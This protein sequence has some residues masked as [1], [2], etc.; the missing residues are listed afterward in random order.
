MKVTEFGLFDTSIG[1]CSI[2]WGEHGLK[3]VRLP[4]ADEARAL[5]PMRRRLPRAPEV[6]SPPL[7]RAAADRVDALLGG[8]R[9]VLSDV[10]PD[11]A[12]V[13]PFE[14]RVYECVCAIVRGAALTYGEVAARMGERGAARAVGEALGR[15]TFA[16]IMPCHRV[17]AAGGR[18]CGFSARDGVATKL[19]MLQGRGGPDRG[20]A[21][22]VRSVAATY[23]CH[24]F[25]MKY[26]AL[27]RVLRRTGDG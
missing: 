23:S 5:A 20:G 14:Q 3:G 17:L 11:M 13:P 25:R 15:N 1:A 10:A 4:K 12:S 8:E 21:G 18:S 27:A 7:V 6:L 2:A 9:D 16:P 26:L 24:E 22:D 19:R